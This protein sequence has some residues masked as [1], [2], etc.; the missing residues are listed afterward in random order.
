[1]V[2]GKTENPIVYCIIFS[3]KTVFS[4]VSPLKKTHPHC[5]SFLVTSNF[6]PQKLQRFSHC[7]NLGLMMIFRK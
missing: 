6:R 2:L 3:N 1:M 7:E 4:W 5:G